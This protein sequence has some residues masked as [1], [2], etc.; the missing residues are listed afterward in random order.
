[1]QDP[2][3]RQEGRP[4]DYQKLVADFSGSIYRQ[5]HRILGSRQDAE[6][7]TQEV[8]LKLYRALGDFRGESQIATWI[9]RITFNVCVSMRQKRRRDHPLALEAE[10]ERLS[11]IP[12]PGAGP[13]DRLA[14]RD[15]RE[16]LA[17]CIAE[18]PEREAAAITLFYMEEKSY[19]DI[20]RILEIPT[21]SVATALHNGRERLRRLLKE[22][23][24]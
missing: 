2:E 8:F 19:A 6:D 21:G 4:L 3:S 13:D 23:R 10:D 17:T 16:R 1:M 9:Y 14:E 24:L 7:A 15:R 11:E 5:A 12:D 18:L 20:S 22:K